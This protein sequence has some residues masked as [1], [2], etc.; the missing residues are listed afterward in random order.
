M[1]Q[2][3]WGLTD[4]MK[5]RDVIILAGGSVLLAAAFPRASLWP[6]AYVGLVPML[7]WLRGRRYRQA[8]L[9]GTLAGLVKCR[10]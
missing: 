4:R 10:H 5:V 7:L 1:G 8:F 2:P 9:G 6:L 3:C